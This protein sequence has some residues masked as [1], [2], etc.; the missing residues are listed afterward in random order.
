MVKYMSKNRN[1]IATI[2]NCPALSA[3]KYSTREE[4]VEVEV[5]ISRISIPVDQMWL[6]R[7][8][9][10]GTLADAKHLENFGCGS[11]LELQYGQQQCK[12]KNYRQKI[13]TNRKAQSHHPSSLPLTRLA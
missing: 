1:G 8:C 13:S 10:L 5:R 9:I 6:G 2:S 7:R 11:I 12:A 3:F 4:C